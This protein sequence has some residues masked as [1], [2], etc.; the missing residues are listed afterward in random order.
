[1]LMVAGAYLSASSFEFVL[2]RVNRSGWNG[3]HSSATPIGH[4][5]E[6]NTAGVAIFTRRSHLVTAVEDMVLEDASLRHD[7]RSLRWVCVVLRLKGV[8]VLLVGLYLIAGIGMTAGNLEFLQQL[9]VLMSLLSM[10]VAVA[11]DWQCI[12]VELFETG[13][14]ERARMT[15]SVPE[16]DSTC[17][18]GGRVIVFF[19][20]STRLVP[21][22]VS[23]SADLEVPW[24]P[25][26]VVKSR[27]WLGFELCL[28]DV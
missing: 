15:L 27:Y 4:S 26:C 7:S 25:H 9:L 2:A 5:L 18:V 17:N 1:M 16:V 8:S 24:G 14:L 19:A 22:I 11:A 20:V 23:V 28:A 13:W 3:F 6:G 12:P 21:L 10:P